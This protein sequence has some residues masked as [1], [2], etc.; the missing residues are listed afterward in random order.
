MI[1]KYQ[2]DTG[3]S[4]ATILGSFLGMLHDVTGGCSLDIDEKS[5]QCIWGR[6]P[7]GRCLEQVQMPTKPPVGWGV[8]ENTQDASFP[9]RTGWSYW[10][11]WISDQRGYNGIYLRW[12]TP[13][14]AS[15]MVHKWWW[16]SESVAVTWFLDKRIWLIVGKHIRNDQDTGTLVT[17][18]WTKEKG[19][20]TITISG[21]HGLGRLGHVDFVLTTTTTKRLYFWSSFSSQIW[22]PQ[23]IW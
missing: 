6:L 7:S 17:A 1:K 9:T 16:T 4:T 22:L 3:R 11:H 8:S 5:I 12:Y 10:T 18:G 13:K 20:W 21:Y 19:E 2:G 14:N 23:D 15:F